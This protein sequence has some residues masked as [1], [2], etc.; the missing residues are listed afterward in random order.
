MS[1]D[2]FVDLDNDWRPVV[3][4]KRHNA[5][6][7]ALEAA[8]GLSGLTIGLSLT[9]GGIFIAGTS[10]SLTELSSKAGTYAG[11]LAKSSLNTAVG[12]LVNTIVHI[13]VSGTT[14]EKST[15][16]LIR[17]TGVFS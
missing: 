7:D 12:S 2:F 11:T 8:A 3:T 10:T 6:T 15:P 14:L 9:P 4:L 17:P 1:D 16:A 5:T 13:V